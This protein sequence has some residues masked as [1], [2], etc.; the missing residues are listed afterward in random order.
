MTTDETTLSIDQLIE[1]G[2][3]D[4]ATGDFEASISK[5]SEACQRLDEKHGDLDPASGDAYFAY[6]RAL[7]Q[8]AIQRNT[9][10]GD[11]AQ[12]SA[13]AIKEQEQAAQP[14]VA[15]TATKAEPSN[16]RFHFDDQPTFGAAAAADDDAED[17]GDDD[18]DDDQDDFESAWQILDVARLIFEKGDDD[19]SKLKLA[20]VLL[21]LSD[22]SM[23]TEKFDEAV[24][25]LKKAI[26]IK[27]TLLPADDR[28]LAELHYRFALALELSIDGIAGALEQMDKVIR[29]LNARIS[30]LEQGT[31]DDEG[32][33]KGKPALSDAD[34]KEIAE[35][36]ELIPE[37]KEKI[38]DLQTK[39][40]TEKQAKE[41]LKSFFGS[42]LNGGSSDT[43]SNA[44]AANVNDLSTLIKRKANDSS[45]NS[46]KKQ[47]QDP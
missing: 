43:S 38:E 21:A 25:D 5:L 9:V 19:A 44:P 20:D 12:E 6:G 37:M 2:K 47:K 41:M 16:P 39:Q 26:D 22:V 34:K 29:V 17:A 27:C 18:D 7:L 28:E 30:T 36:Q 3:Q 11:S 45:G 13:D 14:A 15:A 46:D 35:I 33:G 23:E 31:A 24:P 8:F 32:K 10:L 40:E 4:Y 42:A 1:Q